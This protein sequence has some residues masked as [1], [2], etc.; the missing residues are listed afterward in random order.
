LPQLGVEQFLQAGPAAYTAAPPPA[1]P[2]EQQPLFP[3]LDS[4]NVMCGKKN[5]VI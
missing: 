3:T 2:A 1:A 5:E 4:W